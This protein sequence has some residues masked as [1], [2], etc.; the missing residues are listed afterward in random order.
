[1]LVLLCVLVVVVVYIRHIHIRNGQEV[2]RIVA[3][4]MGAL[5][6]IGKV[7][8]QKAGAYAGTGLAIVTSV[9]ATLWRCRLLSVPRVAV[10]AAVPVVVFF[11]QG[12]C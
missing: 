9:I 10:A 6:M 7:Y 8:P 4:R 11:G 2:G 1:M 3:T 12:C 5:R